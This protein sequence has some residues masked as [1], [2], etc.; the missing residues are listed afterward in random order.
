MPDLS[1]AVGAVRLKNPLIAA[2]AEHLIDAEG[3][4]R[5]LRTGVG[6]VVVKSANETEAG[7]DQLK[8]AEYM[9]L[10]ELWRPVPWGP[11]ALR[12]A[13]IACRSGLAPQPFAQW[14]DETAALD[15]DA[16]AQDSYAVAS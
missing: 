1:T 8:R 7:R 12:S 3:V 15:R 13:T 6:A 2:A 14:L 16:R 11:R 9:V 10:D 5:A 4:R